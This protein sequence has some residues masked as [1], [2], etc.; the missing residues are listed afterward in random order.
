MNFYTHLNFQLYDVYIIG[1]SVKCCNYKG[2]FV[3]LVFDDYILH[4]ERSIS[5]F[6]ESVH[7]QDMSGSLTAR[8]HVFPC[9]Y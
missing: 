4:V 5:G 6:N 3:M 1:N 8:G 9:H 2:T 7:V